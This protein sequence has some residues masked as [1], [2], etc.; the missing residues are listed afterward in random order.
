MKNWTFSQIVSSVVILKFFFFPLQVE[1]G[2][3]LKCGIENGFSRIPWLG[4]F[5]SVNDS[6]A[7]QET[8]T[9]DIENINSSVGLSCTFEKLQ[10]FDYFL[11][12]FMTVAREFFLPTQRHTFGMVSD[13]SLLSSLGVEDSGSWSVM[14]HYSGCPSCSKILKEGD[15]LK[16]FLQ[17]DKSIVREVNVSNM[18]FKP[19]FVHLFSVPLEFSTV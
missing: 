19:F 4:D 17:M 8:D 11:S 7:F 13:K 1:E 15:D 9:W 6:A 3:N 16:S 5:S 10:Q 12:S 18:L 2:A 14:V